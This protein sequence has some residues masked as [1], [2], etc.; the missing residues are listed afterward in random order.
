MATAIP[1]FP[2]WDAAGLVGSTA[3]GL[4]TVPLS[5]GLYLQRSSSHVE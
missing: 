1:G 3:W 5:V 2:T 4:W